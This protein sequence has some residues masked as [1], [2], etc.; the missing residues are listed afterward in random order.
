VDL[1][2]L[3]CLFKSGYNPKVKAALATLREFLSGF[4][5]R[6]RAQRPQMSG[7]TS[8]KHDWPIRIAQTLDK[9]DFSHCLH[10]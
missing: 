4:A 3:I 1:L 9:K 2:V 8:T 6:D 7:T 5:M 10:N